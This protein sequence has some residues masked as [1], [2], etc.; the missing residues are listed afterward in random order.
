MNGLT[1]NEQRTLNAV[2]GEAYS[3]KGTCTETVIIRGYAIMLRCS[4][5]LWPVVVGNEL[6]WF[7]T[8]DIVQIAYDKWRWG[9]CKIEDIPKRGALF[10]LRA[11][12]KH[13]VDK[14][15]ALKIECVASEKLRNYYITEHGFSHEALGDYDTSVIKP[16]SAPNKRADLL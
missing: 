7:E 14:H 2:L 9:H 6:Q 5:P 12:E 10:L 8:L 11:L 15:I 16:L 3:R 1:R 4:R 13:C